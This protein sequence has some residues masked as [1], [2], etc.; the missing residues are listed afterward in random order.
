MNQEIDPTVKVWP[1][2]GENG[3]LRNRTILFAMKQH[4]HPYLARQ[5]S[6]KYAWQSTEGDPHDGRLIGG[7]REIKNKKT[8][9]TQELDRFGLSAQ[10]NTLLLW[11]IDLYWL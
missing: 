2:F 10:R 1:G 6:T 11:S 7:M 5:L 9:E 4:A 3:E 8:I